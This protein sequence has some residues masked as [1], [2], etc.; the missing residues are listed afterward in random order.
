MLQDEPFVR[1]ISKKIQNYFEARRNLTPWRSCRSA[2][3]PRSVF[4][5]RRKMWHCVIAE[6]YWHSMGMSPF[7]EAASRAATREFP[8]IL[9]NLNFITMF[10][11]ALHWSLS[12][13][14][15]SIPHHRWYTHICAATWYNSEVTLLC[16][17][18]L[19]ARDFT[20]MLVSPPAFPCSTLQTERYAIY[21]GK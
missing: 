5:E 7:W 14:D 8:N 16:I 6:V 18:T 11:R 4:W 10:L 15:E 12:W 20:T 19:D 3:R 9:W 17:F 21:E 1:V 2:N 13:A